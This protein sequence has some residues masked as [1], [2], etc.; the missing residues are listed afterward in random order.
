MTVT[1]DGLVALIPEELDADS[2]QVRR[3]VADGL[4]RIQVEPVPIFVDSLSRDQ[5]LDIVDQW[6]RKLNVQVGRVQVRAMTRKWASCSSGGTL[7]LSTAALSLPR[8]L[9]DYIICHELI[10]LKVPNHGMGFRALIR[11]HIPDWEDRHRALMLY[12]G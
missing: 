11:S 4:K 2:E 7:T 9:V 5:I 3:F 10:H 1:P 8:Q 6:C 12:M